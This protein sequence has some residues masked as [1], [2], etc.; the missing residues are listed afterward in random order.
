MFYALAEAWRP[1][2]WG[3]RSPSENEAAQLAQCFEYEWTQAIDH[4]LRHWATPP[5]W[6]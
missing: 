1:E 3:G 4:M 2:M 6:Y 5:T